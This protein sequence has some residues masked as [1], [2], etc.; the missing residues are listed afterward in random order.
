M[1]QL[2]TSAIAFAITMAFSGAVLA[3]TMTK[4]QYK[5]NGKNIAATYKTDKAG[6]NSFSGNA[7]DICVAEA[8]GKENMAKADLNFNYKPSTST[9]YK[10]LIAKADA[11]YSVASERC[12]D[13]AGNDKDVCV[14]EAKA[15]RIHESANAKADMKSTNANTTANEKTSTANV[16]AV[17]KIVAAHEDATIDKRNADFA[18]AKEKCD[19]FAGSAKDNCLNEAK[20][21]FGK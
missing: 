19:A 20:S 7:K 15:A 14:K 1:N 5:M 2:K 6:C 21:R 9:R 18:V 12:D 17:N 10:A 13:K 8:K 11:T 16:K 3:D 4:A